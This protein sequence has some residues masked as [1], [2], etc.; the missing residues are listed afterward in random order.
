MDYIPAIPTTADT[1]FVGFAE[2]DS[3]VFTLVKGSAKDYLKAGDGHERFLAR[4]LTIAGSPIGVF[5]VS[6][7]LIAVGALLLATGLSAEGGALTALLDTLTVVAGFS[8]VLGTLAVLLYVQPWRRAKRRWKTLQAEASPLLV[9]ALPYPWE[10][11][12]GTFQNL[13][14]AEKFCAEALT[15]LTP[16]MRDEVYAAESPHLVAGKVVRDLIELALYPRSIED[17]AQADKAIRAD[18]TARADASRILGL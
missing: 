3:V 10:D 18:E 16:Q 12:P 6:L 8:L 2:D 1:G 11:A 5:I 17:A 15:A 14:E 13:V 4:A 7:A 9:T